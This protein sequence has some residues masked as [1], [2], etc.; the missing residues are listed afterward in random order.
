VLGQIDP[1]EVC[2]EDP[3]FICRQVLEAT[4][5]EWQA[6]AADVLL[7]K[8]FRIAL[9]LLVAWIISGLVGRAIHRFAR[10][11]A[12]QQQPGR[13]IK[14]H[15]KRAPLTDF[16]PSGVLDAGDPSIRAA[17]RAETLAS[18]LKSISSFAIWTIAGITILGELGINLGPLVAGAGVAG[19]A[20]GFGAQSLV[21]DFLAGLFILIED[22]YGVGD[23]IDAGPAS[24]T[25]EAVSLRSTRLR[26][27]NGTVW[28]VPNG[29]IERVGNMS[30][31]WAR[32]LLDVAVGYGA[33]V[34]EAERIIKGAA[35]D[36]WRDPHWAGKVLE[37]PE[38][39]GVENLGPEGVS[40]RLVVKTQPAEQ[41]QI[42]RELRGRIKDALEAADVPL[43]TQQRTIWVRREAGSSRESASG[44][45]RDLDN[46]EDV[47]LDSDEVNT[48]IAEESAVD[49]PP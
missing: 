18:V 8:P 2:G 29:S 28:H 7:A 25:V 4:G 20:L 1:S 43:P 23:V 9:I 22:Q 27:V 46:L 42:L 24:G 40:I 6:E 33:D 45:E 41:F 13:V 37:E 16:L 15:I 3:T 36:V 39:W 21:K 31:Q 19:V 32:A 26:D 35:D 5:S 47:D 12:G 11:L 38:V 30:Q 48:A 14:R 44:D 34:D 17:A 49:D 10:S